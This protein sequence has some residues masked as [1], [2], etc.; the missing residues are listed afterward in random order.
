M[1]PR[2]FKSSF[3]RIRNV[4][5]GTYFCFR[6]TKN[7]SELFQKHFVSATNLSCARKRENIVK[8]CGHVHVLLNVSVLD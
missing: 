4:F 7:V 6:K 5:A 1:L 2:M 8:C 3:A